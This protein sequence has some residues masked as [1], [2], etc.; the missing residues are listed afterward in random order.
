MLEVTLLRLLRSRERM[1]RLGRAV[2]RD[3]L[4]VTTRTIIG[5]M[6]AY[7]QDSP[8]AQEIT[9][10]PFF[11]YFCMRHPTLSPEQRELYRARLSDALMGEADPALERGILGRLV[12]AEA[13]SNMA[14]LLET[15]NAGGEIDLYNAMR[16]EVDSLEKALDKK[17][18]VPEVEESIADILQETI[19]DSGL[20][21]RLSGLNDV[22]PPLRGGDFVI[23][24]GRVGKGKTTGVMSEAGF[25]AAQFDSY[26]GVGHNRALVWLCNEGP[27][28]KIKNTAYRSV[29]NATQA[30]L[31][32]W[33]QDGTLA[34]RYAEA[35][36]GDPNRIRVMNVHGF[37][38][39]QIEAILARVKPGLLVVDMLDNVKFSEGAING[40]DRSDET[41]EA[42]YQMARLWAVKYDCP[43]IGTSQTNGLAV[44]LQWPGSHMLK[45]STTGKQGAAE[46]MIMM[47]DVDSLPM[48]RFISVPKMK[49]HRPG[50]P[51]YPRFEVLFDGERAR[52]NMPTEAS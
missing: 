17:A 1:R 20:R 6:E 4:D 7:F 42:G 30:D 35:L 46:L 48:S 24:A 12:Q 34:S 39:Y 32:Q 13:A 25:M 29:L 14:G 18:T 36:G 9:V 28:K 19:D 11:V 52:L 8:D 2:P 44:N 47:G 22:L 33:T 31:I 21:W 38:S 50:A 49:E 37:N 40:G 16:A 3:A 15:W 43:V 10:D 51:A 45:G 5:D 26:Y 23:Y 27:G 41:L